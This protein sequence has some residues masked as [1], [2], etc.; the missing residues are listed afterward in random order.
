MLTDPRTRYRAGLALALLASLVMLWLIPAVGIIGVEG[1]SFDL[2]YL[3]VLAFGIGGAVVAR[4]RPDGMVRAML[5]MVAALAV[6]A[7]IALL[8]GKHTS[9]ATSVLEVL[10]L[11]GMFAVLFGAAAWLFRT[12]A[13]RQPT[14]GP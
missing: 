3:G 5:T 1:D 13:Q 4:L 14:P 2:F 12:S 8:A 11:N 6:L 7:V 10:G 9:P